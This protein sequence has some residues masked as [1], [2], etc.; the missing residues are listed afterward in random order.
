[1]RDQPKSLR[2]HLQELR[3]RL[4]IALAAVAVTTVLS[5][6]FWERIVDF[7]LV[8]ADDLTEIEGRLVFIEVTEMFGVMMKV[9][10][11]AGLVIASP[12]VFMQTIMFVAPALT[13]KEKLYLYSFVP[14]V[15]LSFFAGAAFGYYVLIPPAI[16]FLVGF[17]NDI[18]Q[19]TIRISNYVNVVV[20]LLFWMGLVFETPVV[21]FLLAKLR[22]VKPSAYSKFRRPWV[23]IAFVLGAIITPTFDPVNQTLVAAPL[24]VLYEIGLWLSKLAAREGKRARTRVAQTQGT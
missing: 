22:V 16:E 24:I 14:A 8:P 12:V 19:P 5:F 7:L 3:K 18:A 2:V 9:S 4:T 21:M 23:V 1:M 10:M 11:M 15:L 17:G 6:I 13:A 20:M